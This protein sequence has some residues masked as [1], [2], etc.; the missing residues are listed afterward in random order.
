MNFQE[1]ISSKLHLVDL[2]GSERLAKSQS[3]DQLKKEGKH[4][5]LSL[6]YLEQVIRALQ[7]S[8]INH[9]KNI[10]IPYRNSMLTSVL[11]GSL[12]GNCKSIFIA[13]LSPRH[14]DFEESLSTCRFMRRCREVP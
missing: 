7:R 6:H 5:N 9:E 8:S 4:I 10:F 2:A 1:I 14:E 12:G 13:T 11:R 3:K